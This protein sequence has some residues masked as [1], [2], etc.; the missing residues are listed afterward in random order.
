MDGNKVE[1][2]FN[3]SGRLLCR[4]GEG[5]EGKEEE[6]IGG[7]AAAEKGGFVSDALFLKEFC[8]PN[9]YQYW[10]LQKNTLSL[11]TFEILIF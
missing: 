4:S 2:N 8:F 6:A 3:S 1:A 5:G 7:V 10:K 9:V 11:Y